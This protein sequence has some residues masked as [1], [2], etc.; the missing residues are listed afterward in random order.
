MSRI[1]TFI[2]FS[3]LTGCIISHIYGSTFIVM[4]FFF[5]KTWHLEA[6]TGKT[7]IIL[8]LWQVRK[9]RSN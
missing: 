1:C 5:C 2:N 9:A 4:V 6:N 7:K 3:F 8:D